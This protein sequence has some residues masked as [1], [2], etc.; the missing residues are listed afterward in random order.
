MIPAPSEL[1]QMNQCVEFMEKVETTLQ[2]IG[3]R[4]QHPRIMALASSTTGL[5]S[6]IQDFVEGKN[7]P[8]E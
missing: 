3:Q 1:Y 5:R 7:T 8:T 4:T 6:A 2:K